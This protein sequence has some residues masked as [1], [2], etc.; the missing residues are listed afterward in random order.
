MLRRKN[1]NAQYLSRSRIAVPKKE[2]CKS[3]TNSTP[4]SPPSKMSDDQEMYEVE[5]DNNDNTWSEDEEDCSNQAAAHDN[6]EHNLEFRTKRQSSL[7]NV[8]ASNAAALEHQLTVDR[9]SHAL[10]EPRT[11][12]LQMSHAGDGVSPVLQATSHELE[13]NLK[14]SAVSHQLGRR[15]SLQELVERGV[16]PNKP[17]QLSSVLAAPAKELE[18]NM[19]HDSLHTGLSVAQRKH[20][21]LANANSSKGAQP[22]SQ[23]PLTVKER[24]EQYKQVAASSAT[25]SYSPAKEPVIAEDASSSPGLSLKERLL[26]YTT[27]ASTSNIKKQVDVSAEMAVREEK[28]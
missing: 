8:L 17:D 3:F 4:Q 10:H 20:E 19:R 12:G 5:D 26:A 6:L 21:Y 11:S 28:E 16:L 2:L 23:Q 15:S 7:S 9:L 27:T 1:P 18:K 13:K 14:A 22:D 24:M 25:K